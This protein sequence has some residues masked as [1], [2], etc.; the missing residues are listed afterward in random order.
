MFVTIISTEIISD[1]Y[2]NTI[3][4]GFQFS[5]LEEPKMVSCKKGWFDR[6]MVGKQVKMVNEYSK[7]KFYGAT[8]NVLHAELG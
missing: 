8:D 6:A 1:G 7:I 4:I 3:M 5:R 2:T